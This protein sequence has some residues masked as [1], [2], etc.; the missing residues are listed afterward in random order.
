MATIDLLRKERIRKLEALKKHG[1]DPYPATCQRNQTIIEA[2][3]MEGKSVAVTGRIMNVR[4]HGKLVF[5][6]LYDE[7]G[8]IQVAFKADLLKKESFSL[9]SLIDVGDFLAVSG[10]VGETT[11][12]ETTV[13]ADD[14][15]LITKSLR[16]LPDKW[17]GFKDVE[18]RYRQR[19]VDLIINPEV[20][21]I[22]ITRT[23]VIK[24]LR[25]YLDN[26]GFFEVETPVLQPIY[27]GASAKP[28]IT[29]HNA[30][31]TDLF[32][33]ISDELYLKRLIAGGFEKVYEVGKDFR[34]E[35]IDKEHNPEFT[36]L[37]FY[38]AY[39]NYDTLMKY[40]EKMLS[41]LVEEIKGSLKFSYQGIK[42]DFSPPWQ[43][44]TYREGIQKYSGIDIDKTTSERE[45]K[46]EIA[47]NK[48]NVNLA[49][50]VG[51]GAILDEL[52]KT[53]ARPHLIGPLF[54]TDRP[55]AFVT[56]AKRLPE[57]PDKTASFQLLVAG[58][59]LINAYN[60][61]NDPIDQAAR[62][63]ESEK[64][65]EHGQSQHE[66]YDDDY[67]RAL[68]YGM[69]PTAGWGMGID[70]LVSVLTDQHSL[71]EVILFPTLRP[72]NF[73]SE[74]PKERNVKITSGVKGVTGSV[75]RKKAWEILTN[76]MKNQNL[77]RHCLAVEAAMKA[78]AR[79][80]KENEELWGIAGLMHDADYELTKDDT[81]KHALTSASWL[82]EVGVDER[83]INAVLSHGW[84]FVEGCPEPKNNL[85][86]SLY[87]SDDLTGLIVAVALVRPDKK[88][89]SVN[90]DS[91]MKKWD[92]KTF[93]AGANREQIASCE[94][95]LGIKIPE[96]VSIVLSAMQSISKDLGL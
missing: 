86:W 43:R 84:K 8:K 44:I 13:F 1:I 22:F 10:K 57:D 79:H 61:L 66:A 74:V 76:R 67:I 24:F 9:L 85:E 75:D 30:L 18:E 14:F 35:G 68:E 93:A 21:K 59:E 94:E 56:L 15:Q 33:R 3:K 83:I 65:G 27:G 7:S 50:I 71:K 78:L 19:Y 34:N 36:Q 69:P 42:L 4:G 41:S 28:F 60:E 51:Y 29:H 54:L 63:R 81:T 87:C 12:G 89:S 6:D 90:L 38:W 37:E 23:K 49:D 31:D 70:R 20:K 11:A 88:I 80:F 82:K 26:D 73:K 77:I 46:A 58:R 16:P 52:Y 62:W 5:A 48:I 32:L 96:F 45:L 25:N 40:T 55:T 64:L 95:K 53:V 72:L 47:K 92:S 17:Y 2:R 39:S 91:V